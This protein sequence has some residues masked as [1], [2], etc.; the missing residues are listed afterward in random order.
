MVS[1][2]SCRNAGTLAVTD[3]WGSEVRERAMLSFL[4]VLM[5]API[6]VAA[7]SD[8]DEQAVLTILFRIRAGEVLPEEVLDRQI[9]YRG[10]P[11]LDQSFSKSEGLRCQCGAPSGR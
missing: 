11:D 1:L 5:L 9:G 10:L 4:A 6:L 2:Q 7:S 8:G 3:F